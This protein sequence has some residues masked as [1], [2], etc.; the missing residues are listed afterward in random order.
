MLNH[1]VDLKASDFMPSKFEYH[2]RAVR[3]GLGFKAL[4]AAYPLVVDSIL[5]G[6]TLPALLKLDVLPT[7]VNKPIPIIPIMEN[8]SSN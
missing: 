7:K 8:E 6:I 4:Q 3:R 5:V 1:T 2:V